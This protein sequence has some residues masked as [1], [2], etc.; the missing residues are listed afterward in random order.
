MARNAIA[1]ALRAKRTAVHHRG[2][3]VEQSLPASPHLA[4]SSKRRPCAYSSTRSSLAL[5][6]A[7]RPQPQNSPCPRGVTLCVVS[8]KEAEMP[9]AATIGD[10]A[11]HNAIVV[12]AVSNPPEPAGKQSSRCFWNWSTSDRDPHRGRAAVGA[13]RSREARERRHSPN[14]SRSAHTCR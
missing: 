11:P 7:R 10:A 6:G 8:Q 12:W 1:P 4:K 14:P 2:S 9:P 5:E 3:T 13:R